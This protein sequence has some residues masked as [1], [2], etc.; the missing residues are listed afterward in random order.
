MPPDAIRYI[1]GRPFTL[2]SDPGRRVYGER[3]VNIDGKEYREWSP[4]RSKLSAYLCL[5]GR[6]FPFTDSSNVL[7]LGAASGTTASHISDIVVGGR[8]YCVEISPRAF[9][10]LVNVC[11]NRKNMMP[12]L[13]DAAAPD[14]YGFAADDVGIVYQDVAQKGQA[15]MLADNMEFFSARYGIVSV[16]ARSEDVT[17]SPDRIFEKARE[18]LEGRGMKILDMRSL[19]PHEKAHAMIVVEALP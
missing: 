16:K 3:L 1:D 9:R 5:G 7:Y 10:D 15:D 18:R 14:G 12:I 8:I 19:E 11:G 17:A 4:N 13:G 2:S 6:C